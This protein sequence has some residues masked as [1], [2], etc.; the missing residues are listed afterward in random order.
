MATYATHFDSC[1]CRSHSAAL[2]RFSDGAVEIAERMAVIG[3]T[4]EQAGNENPYMLKI[5][6]TD[7][8]GLVQ[9]INAASRA[10]WGAYS[11]PAFIPKF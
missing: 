8:R 4:V 2:A 7:G 9:A 3:A 6:R 1:D 10:A 11:E 5:S